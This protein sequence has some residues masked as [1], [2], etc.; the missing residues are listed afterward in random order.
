M[1]LRD[2]F[3]YIFA[4]V[5]TA[6]LG[7][8][9]TIGLTWILSPEAYGIYGFG[10]V[11]IGLGCNVLFDW[12]AVSYVRLNQSKRD[13]P[14][15]MTTVIGSFAA[16]CAISAAAVG[17]AE[18]GGLPGEAWLLLLGVWAYAWFEFTS[19]I[20]V[21]NFRPIRYLLMN[22]TRNALIL[23]G[24]LAVAYEIGSAPA[25]LGAGFFAMAL[26]G[27]L[28]L[29]D[30]AMRLHGGFDRATARAMLI[31][32]VPIGLTGVCSGIAVFANRALL[33]TMA[34]TRSVAFLTAAS[35]LVHGSIGIL[36]TGVG[37]A[38]FP[39]AVRAVE[40]GDPV[41]IKR[42]LS[43]NFTFLIG[44]YMPATVGLSLVAPQIA[45][46]L[47]QPDYRAPVVEMMPWLAAAAALQG[48]RAH[49]VDLAFQ[50][51][52]RTWRLVEVTASSAA[53]NLA[54]SYLLIPIWGYQGAAVATTIAVFASFIYALALSR[55]VFV[56]PWPGREI[57]RVVVA[58]L[59]M[60]A[61][62]VFGPAWHGIFGLAAKILV[63][64]LAYGIA[65]VALDLLGLRAVLL[66]K[67]GAR[68][69]GRV[70]RR[71][72]WRKPGWNKAAAE[73]L[74]N[75]NARAQQPTSMESERD[76]RGGII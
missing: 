31:Y 42:Q 67:Y 37:S 25:V 59:A 51:G 22:V 58:T 63:G 24:C 71:M 49:Y 62:L 56:L 12:L 16:G 28:Y 1:L 35:A 47:L 60:A 8:A 41:E 15:F 74:A 36:G 72:P 75:D 66:G 18:I 65:A 44:I 33:L 11:A 68:F 2:G 3:I 57:V 61:A 10:L 45:D 32:G 27:C 14:R 43:H 29:N 17:I 64:M 70:G 30:G 5:L 34:D 26:S 55:R 7:F 21:V 39:L 52:N 76:A 9:T 13:D 54:L 4:R 40:S 6:G 38:T 53:V 46:V 23:I 19:Q 69:G 20:Q 73:N 50:L 48:I